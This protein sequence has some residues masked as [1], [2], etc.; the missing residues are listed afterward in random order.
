[1]KTLKNTHFKEVGKDINCLIESNAQYELAK[2]SIFH[3]IGIMHLWDKVKRVWIIGDTKDYI[4]LFDFE[5]T[6]ERNEYGVYGGDWYEFYSSRLRIPYK[7]N[8]MVILKKNN[9]Q[10]TYCL[11]EIYAVLNENKLFF[12]C[13]FQYIS[14]NT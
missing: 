1:M 6:K 2:G 7:L 3:G 12:K 4:N 14:T 5:R 8:K 10:H 13:H 11:N 9:E